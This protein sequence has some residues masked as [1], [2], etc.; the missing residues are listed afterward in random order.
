M[1]AR[2]VILGW[3][4]SDHM[5]I[6]KSSVRRE[7]GF[8]IQPHQVWVET[9]AECGEAALPC[10]GSPCALQGN[11][12]ILLAHEREM[13]PRSRCSLRAKVVP[14][15]SL[16]GS[17][18]TAIGSS[19]ITFSPTWSCFSSC[20][21]ASPWQLRTPCATS[22]LG[23]KYATSSFPRCCCSSARSRTSAE[24]TKGCSRGFGSASLPWF[25]PHVGC[26][27]NH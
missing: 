10:T 6:T 1:K 7:W 9:T 3:Q 25:L 5:E 2:D 11:P 27:W 23:T 24:G 4:V 8:S 20:S 19:M 26:V 12:L 22:P 21:A 14:L 16:A 17:V 18:C 13:F 15:V